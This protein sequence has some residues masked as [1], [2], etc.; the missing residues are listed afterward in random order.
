ME[1]TLKNKIISKESKIKYLLRIISKAKCVSMNFQFS[2]DN[3]M[4][5]EKTKICGGCRM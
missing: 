5:L 1:K 3:E 4:K 2:G